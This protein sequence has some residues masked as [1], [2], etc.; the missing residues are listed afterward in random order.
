MGGRCVVRLT[1]LGSGDAFGSGGRLHSAYLV[2]APGTTLLVDCGPTVLQALKQMHVPPERLDAVL[3]SHLHGDH[4]GGV[5]F[6]LM[7][8]R[9][10]SARTRPVVIAGPGDTQRRVCALYAALY[11]RSASEP[12]PHPIAWQRVVAREP[13]TVAGVRVTALP[14]PHAPELE[15]FGYRLE[16]GGRT[17]FY[18]GDTAWTDEFV[19]Q[20]RDV[21]LFLCECSTWETRLDL[22]VSYPE[23]AGR[24]RG[25]GCKRLVLTHLGREPLARL[26]EITLECARD[27]MV[28]EL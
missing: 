10:D 3:L 7:D 20:A 16:V 19:A 1:V 27:G 12:P 26:G 6:L 18:S 8:Y 13:T 5:P 21:D 15:C 11:E 17:I 25:L 23:I 2:E 4:F 9:Y 24:A 14:V 22:H 28:I